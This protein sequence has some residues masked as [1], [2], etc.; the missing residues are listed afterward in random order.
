VA[1][2]VSRAAFGALVLVSVLV[3]GTTGI[4][5]DDSDVQALLPDVADQ[6]EQLADLGYTRGYS[7]YWTSSIVTLLS[8]GRAPVLPAHCIVGR[9]SAPHVWLVDMGQFE[10]AA[11]D[12]ADRSF[13]VVDRREGLR[14]T[15]P[16]PDLL[17]QHGAPSDVIELT[18]EI[19]IWLYPNRDVVADLADPT[20]P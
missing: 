10:R 16:E 19:H 11:G 6:V 2:P 7:G 18:P 4:V 13:I 20:A 15:C 8:D 9:R 12:P 1:A 5:R 3:A 14:L 17:D